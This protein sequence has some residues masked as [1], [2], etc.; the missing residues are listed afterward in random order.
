MT[1]GHPRTVTDAAAAL[2]AGE[3]TSVGLTR[4]AIALADRADQAL[5]VYV[6]RFDNG[7]LDAAERADRELK[8]GL[9]RGPLHGIPI[10]VKDTIAV[11]EGPTTA[12]SVVLDRAWG[13]GRDAPV[14]ARLKAAGAVITGKTTAMEFACGMPDPAKPFPVP[15][16]PWR[17]DAWTGGSSSGTAAGVAAGMFLAGL[18]SDTG[19]SIRMPAAFCGVTGL[20]PTFGLVPKSGCVPMAHSLDRIGPMARSARDCAALLNIMAGAHPSDP[21]SVR[22][23]AQTDVPAAD[24]SGV[25]AD[26]SDVRVGVV[27]EGHFPDGTDPALGD[28]FDKAVEVLAGL[29]A[30]VRTVTLPYRQEMITTLYVVSSCEALAYHRGD[31]A[32]RWDD[33]APHTRRLIATGAMMSGA[34]YVQAQ[35]VRRVG[36]DAVQRLFGEVDVI[37]C[38][39]ASVGA[40]SFDSLAGDDGHLRTDALYPM[41]HTPYWS[42]LGN[43]VLAVP[44]GLTAAGLPLSMQLAGPAFGE[45][46]VLRAG[47]AFQRQ[48]DWHLRAPGLDDITERVGHDR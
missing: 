42:G 20:M 10:G 38:P 13:E 28:A 33:Y 37:A 19:G 9:D 46:A 41:I 15:R 23:P 45:A 16:N 39:T 43:P 14:V 30:S 1:T 34:D 31:L 2:R 17:P 25:R 8:A 32:L 5:G 4:A 24:L 7:A 40:P 36:Q 44:I 47:D 12:Q 29:G 48:T 22:Y 11:A 6:N 35:R 21:D 18:G 27:R 3:A 26:L